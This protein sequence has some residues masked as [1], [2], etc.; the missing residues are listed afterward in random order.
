MWYA[1]FLTGP[2]LNPRLPAQR[3]RLLEMPV[4]G[5]GVQEPCHDAH[6]NQRQ[7]MNLCQNEVGRYEGYAPSGSISTG[8]PRGTW[9]GPLRKTR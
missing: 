2:K 7:S 1:Y 6:A 5:Q 3:Q 9:M 8:T 4:D